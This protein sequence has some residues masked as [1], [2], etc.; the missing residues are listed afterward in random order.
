MKTKRIVALGSVVLVSWLSACGGE[1]HP[2]VGASPVEDAGLPGVGGAGGGAGGSGGQVAGGGAPGQG[3]SGGVADGLC[4]TEDRDDDYA[5]GLVKVGEAGY[6]VTL[7]ASDPAPPERGDNTWTVA[8]IDP[9]GAP[10]GGLEL[11]VYP[12]MPDHGHG[13]PKQ[14]TVEAAGAAGTYTLTPVNLSMSGL[15][16]VRIKLV[17][18][19]TSTEL[20]RVTFAFCVDA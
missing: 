17:D 8:V 5:P 18:P 16:T 14:V 7:V 4:A 10:L 2:A 13:S 3:G 6:S 1:T 15:W 11:D 20:D 19:G 9:G 12:Y